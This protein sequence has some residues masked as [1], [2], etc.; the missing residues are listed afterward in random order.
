MRDYREFAELLGKTL[1]DVTLGHD[2]VRFDVAGGTAYLLEHQQDCCE[3]VYVESVVGDLA[4]LIGEPIT[5]AEEVSH[6]DNP[7]HGAAT[8]SHTWTFYKLDTRK[9]GVTIRF[10]GE[11]NG[12]YSESVDFVKVQ[13]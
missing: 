10:L 9:G 7:P 6:S 8:E 5:R 12:Y 4:D 2:T 13:A 11:S 3:Y 1:T